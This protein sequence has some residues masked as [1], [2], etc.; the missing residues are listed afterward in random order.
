MQWAGYILHDRELEKEALQEVFIRIWFNREQLPQ[1]DLL[2]AWLK[3]IT[4][5]RCLTMLQARA[6]RAVRERALQVNG[7]SDEAAGRVSYHELQAAVEQAVAI[8]PPQRRQ[9]YKMSREKGMSSAEIARTLQ[10]SPGTVRNATSMALT[11][12]REYL[13]AHGQYV[14]LFL[15]LLGQS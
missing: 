11:T 12:I 5:N 15:L 3:K 8:L 2:S 10:L 1:I 13:M 6:R 14:P 4:V 9:I 7:H